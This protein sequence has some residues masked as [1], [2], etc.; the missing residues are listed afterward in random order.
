[1]AVIIDAIWMTTRSRNL[2]AFKSNNP[3]VTIENCSFIEFDI[4]RIHFRCFVKP[5]RKALGNSD[6]FL[7]RDIRLRSGSNRFYPITSPIPRLFS[8]QAYPFA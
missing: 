2:N 3:M 1:L 6:S 4:V 8:I 7:S 5:L